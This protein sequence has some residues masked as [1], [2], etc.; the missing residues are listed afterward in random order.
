MTRRGC[1]KTVAL[2]ITLLAAIVTFAPAAPA[3]QDPPATVEIGSGPVGDRTIA[4]VGRNQYGADTV[5]LFGYLTAV[6]SLAPDLIYT[7]AP[8]GIATARFTYAG[9]AAISSRTPRGDVTTIVAAGTV[10]VFLDESG[11]TSWDDPG[12]FADGEPVAELTIQLRETAQRQAPGVGVVVGDATL[13][14]VVARDLTIGNVPYRFGSNGLEQ[15]FRYIG[16]PLPGADAG[17]TPGVGVTGAAS[18][19]RR[20]SIAVR[21]GGPAASP[22]AAVAQTCPDLQPWVSQASAALDRAQAIGGEAGAADATTAQQAAAEVLALATAQRAAEPPET[23]AEANRLVVTAL[24]TSA[25]GLQ[26]VASGL[27]NQDDAL[28]AQGRTVLADGEGLIDRAR[29]TLAALESTCA[30]PTT[31]P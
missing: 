19:T 20:T 1:R 16:T 6:N 4:F 31:S 26:T 12:S 15:R 22:V 8:P 25:R 7:G 9:D 14:Q 5:S 24:S 29:E 3:R 17:Q 2:L 23:A 30:A 28:V 11:G 13:V 18:V 27:A 10:R 21:L